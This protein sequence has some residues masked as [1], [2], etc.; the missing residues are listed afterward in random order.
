MF[1]VS[2]GISITKVS[3][4]TIWYTVFLPEGSVGRKQMLR[5]CEGLRSL[6]GG[7]EQL[8]LMQLSCK[9]GFG[10]LVLWKL[11]ILE[12]L[13]YKCS[14]NKSGKLQSVVGNGLGRRWDKIWGSLG[15][16]SKQRCSHYRGL[17]WR[18]RPV[19]L[20]TCSEDRTWSGQVYTNAGPSWHSQYNPVI[21][22]HPIH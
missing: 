15:L 19:V 1:R 4:L 13:E 12:G 5:P 2:P 6:W 3:P 20:S 9:Y 18:W 11:A 14:R 7:K 21:G 22:S 17:A 10:V 16:E 8:D